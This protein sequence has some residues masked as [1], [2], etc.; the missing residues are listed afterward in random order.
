MSAAGLVFAS[1]GFG[2][3]YAWSAGAPYGY[4]MAGLTVL[5]ACA[6]EC[7]KPLAL[8][9]ALSAF[10]SFAIIRGGALALLAAVAVAYSLTAEL[11]L[12]ATARGDLVAQRVADA[13]AA[14][15][16]DGQRDRLETELSMLADIRPSA[17]IKA[18]IGGLLADQRIGD[19]SVMDG[20]RSKAACPRVSAL[21]AEL[22]QAERKEQLELGLAALQPT[23]A[24]AATD[25]T[26]DPG[27]HALST[28]LA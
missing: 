7:A 9:S 25:K 1:A 13:K 8:A 26:S 6:L 15:S 18:E 19:C 2:S 24:P 20:P 17:T 5:M 4:L 3:V 10:R 12:M 11:S 23:G 16:V 22:G 21:R 14:R 27:A 28:Y